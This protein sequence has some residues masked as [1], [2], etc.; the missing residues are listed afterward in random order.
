MQITGLFHVAIKAASLEATE[1]FYCQVLGLALAERPPLKVPGLW[2]KTSTSEG[3]VLIHVYGGDV[4]KNPDGTHPVG[5]NAVDHVA[6][7][8]HGFNDMKKALAARGI[9]FRERPVPGGPLWQL[10][11]YD[12]NGIQ[13]E[14]NF[15]S[16][17]ESGPGPDPGND[18]QRGVN[19]FE[20]EAYRALE[21]T[22]R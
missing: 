7:S 15:H 2:L 4:A 11:T 8:A 10:F 6:L 20:P 3:E 21:G 1:R 13:L 16:G 18:Q 12:P 14:L 22:G 19:W 17:A 5:G 9:P